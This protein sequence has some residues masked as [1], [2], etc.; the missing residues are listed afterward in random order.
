MG[1]FIITTKRFVLRPYRWSDAAVL[2][3]NINDRKIYR[4]TLHIPYPY[5]LRDAKVWFKKAIPEYK[6]KNPAAVHLAIDIDGEV[7]GCVGLTNIVPG[8]KAE[9]GYWLAPRLW[10]QGIVSEAVGR[11]VEFAFKKMKLHRIY[12]Y[13]F[14]PN[15]ASMRILEK[16]GFR[17][18]GMLRKNVRKDKVLRD[19]YLYAKVS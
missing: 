15:R 16:N 9:I 4:Y 10:G 18:E 11:V 2:A 12:A 13:V 14:L 6:K 7:V 3:G 8:H 17:R 5:A 1:Q 19:E